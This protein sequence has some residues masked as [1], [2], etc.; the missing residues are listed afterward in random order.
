[1]EKDLQDVKQYLES[2]LEEFSD[3]YENYGI[4]MDNETQL[5]EKALKRVNKLLTESLEYSI[6]S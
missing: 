2:T 6:A 1:M 5:I 4:D 3:A